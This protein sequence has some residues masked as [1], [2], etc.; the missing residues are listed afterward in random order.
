MLDRAMIGCERWEGEAQLVDADGRVIDIQA[1]STP[2]PS[3]GSRGSGM[4]AVIVDITERKAAEIERQRLAVTDQLTGLP[5]RTRFIERLQ[6][7]LSTLEP[8]QVVS[9]FFINVDQ[10]RD[11]N[12]SLGHMRRSRLDRRRQSPAGGRGRRRD[13]GAVCGRYLFGD[14]AN[15]QRLT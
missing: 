3:L 1:T 13:G 10:V 15:Q 11:L 12:A 14:C 6:L 7:A 4:V 9:V 5:N 8:D 2:I